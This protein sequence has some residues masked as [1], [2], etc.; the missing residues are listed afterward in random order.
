[1]VELQLYQHLQQMLHILLHEQASS[2][3]VTAAAV[4]DPCVPYSVHWSSYEAQWVQMCEQV[5]VHSM[6]ASTLQ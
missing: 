4:R 3:G 2:G 6:P 5:L 1:M